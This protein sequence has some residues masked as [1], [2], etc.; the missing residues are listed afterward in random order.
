VKTQVDILREDLVR[1]VEKITMANVA[2]P[3]KFWALYSTSFYERMFQKI[4]NKKKLDSVYQIM[5]SK[6][7]RDDAKKALE[8]FYRLRTQ[9]LEGTFKWEHK[10]N[11]S[12][13][14]NIIRE[15]IDIL[16]EVNDQYLL[17][18][19]QLKEMLEKVEKNIRNKFKGG[20][21]SETAVVDSVK[22]TINTYVGKLK[23]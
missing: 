7:K 2:D 22:Q 4:N 17:T 19:T 3:V 18:G 1:E 10:M 6:L 14:R 15:E 13:L 9:E 20:N 16:T 11:K 23:Q 12:D 5:L 8:F 21:P